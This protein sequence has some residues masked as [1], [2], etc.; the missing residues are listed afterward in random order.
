MNNKGITPIIAI[1]LLLMMTVAVAGAAF[2]WLTRIQNQLQGGVE[3]FQS[4]S[5]TQMA[6]RVEVLDADYVKSTSYA[7]LTI[8]LQNTG[9]T[10][11][12]LP[13]SST[14]PTTTWILK[15]ENGVAKCSSDWSG[16][17][18]VNCTE[19]CGSNILIDVG[20]IK[21]VVLNISSGSSCWLGEASGRL[22]SFTIDFSGKTTT[23]GSFVY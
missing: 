19:G 10:K 12:P 17:A 7:N 15:D 16:A 5:L 11:I 2:F 3:S 20:Q 14:Y 8:F 13:N 4:T 22:Y 6:S 9:N 18:G 1:I 23:S 21:K